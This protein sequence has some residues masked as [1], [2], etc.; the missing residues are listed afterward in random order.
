MKAS[1]ITNLNNIE[2]ASVGTTRLKSMYVGLEKVW[3][4]DPVTYELEA[5]SRIVP[6][7]SGFSNGLT[8]DET[9]CFQVEYRFKKT[10]GGVVTYVNHNDVEL[11][12]GTY[13]TLSDITKLTNWGINGIVEGALKN[14]PSHTMANYCFNTIT[15]PCTGWHTE[16]SQTINNNLTLT[17]DGP[18]PNLTC[19][20]VVPRLAIFVKNSTTTYDNWTSN[21]GYTWTT[22]GS[23]DYLTVCGE[24]RVAVTFTQTST[25]LKGQA[26]VTN[27]LGYYTGSHFTSCVLSQSD[28]YTGATP[29]AVSYLTNFV[30]IGSSQYQARFSVQSLCQ[31]SSNTY[32]LVVFKLRG[33]ISYG[34]PEVFVNK[35]YVKEGIKLENTR[36]LSKLA[37]TQSNI[38][39]PILTG[40]GP[41][42]NIDLGTISLKRDRYQGKQFL[43]K[44]SNCQLGCAEQFT[45]IDSNTTNPNYITSSSIASISQNKLTVNAY[46]GVASQETVTCSYSYTLTTNEEWADGSTTSTKTVSRSVVRPANNYATGYPRT[47]YSYTLP[48]NSSYITVYNGSLKT[49]PDRVEL[50]RLGGS[51]V[52]QCNQN[53]IVY[54]KYTCGGNEFIYSNT[55]TTVNISKY[56]LNGTTTQGNNYSETYPD[57]CSGVHQEINRSLTLQVVDPN[58]TTVTVKTMPVVILANPY[59]NITTETTVYYKVTNFKL[60][61]NSTDYDSGTL[62]VTY[63]STTLLIV[64]TWESKSITTVKYWYGTTICNTTTDSGT[65][66]SSSDPG[67]AINVSGLPTWMSQNGRNINVDSYTGCVISRSDS[68]FTLSFSAT[69][70]SG[71]YSESFGIIQMA[72]PSLFALSCNKET[73]LVDS[74][75]TEVVYKVQAS[76]LPQLKWNSSTIT[77]AHWTDN[78]Y[79]QMPSPNWRSFAKNTCTNFT[80]TT[81]YVK[82]NI[83]ANTTCNNKSHNVTFDNCQGTSNGINY[84]SAPKVSF[85]QGGIPKTYKA[86][87]TVSAGLVPV[88][89]TKLPFRVDGLYA[90]YCNNT[91]ISSQSASFSSWSFQYYVLE[92]L[93]SSSPWLPMGG[94]YTLKKHSSMN[95]IVITGHVVSKQYC[96]AI[97]KNS[98]TGTY[99]GVSIEYDGVQTTINGQAA[100]L[101]GINQC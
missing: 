88:N 55:N 85:T 39:M 10:V 28:V 95:N 80:V 5:R 54:H 41:W 56:I 60:R 11:P 25:S 12:A 77:S 23:S 9:N 21:G 24:N 31:V 50:T 59:T 82:L 14:H 98:I 72:N 91:L 45:F 52:F 53:T 73:G 22:F 76:C 70:G 4:P 69:D 42:S 48:H 17:I 71:A 58:N 19:H 99:N 33:P 79:N 29:L 38:T 89:C 94:S 2:V 40:C 68:S 66:V 51:I 32:V 15:I 101:S 7:N 84:N 81:V 57:N 16:V 37:L 92:R 74:S 1:T 13:L 44:I 67:N 87:F 97:L 3:P 27:Y 6:L 47:T 49:N 65:W 36:I 78:W 63:P 61:Y 62:V 8:Y 93:N 43:G 18:Q 35:Y 30:S 86:L 83:G 96:I 90:T 100:Y 46:T 64:P 34:S 26:I 75:T 20:F